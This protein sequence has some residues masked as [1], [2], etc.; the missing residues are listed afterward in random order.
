MVFFS[1]PPWVSRSIWPNDWNAKIVPTT[2]A[3]KI[4]G[5]SIGSVTCQKRDHA[6]GAVDPRRFEQLVGHALQ[7]GRH[8]DEREPERSAR[9]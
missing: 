1:G 9:W 7:P 4:V 2:T 8:Q 5:D 3:K 6:P